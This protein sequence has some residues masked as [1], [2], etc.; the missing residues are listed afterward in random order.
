[1]ITK[2]CNS[3]QLC[4]LVLGLSLVR[5]VVLCEGVF[6]ASEVVNG[7][8]QLLQTQF[9]DVD[10]FQ[11][12]TGGG[13][14]HYERDYG[15][16][17]EI[18]YG[19]NHY[20]TVRKKDDQEWVDIYDHL[21]TCTLSR[22]FENPM[23]QMFGKTGMRNLTGVFHPCS[24]QSLNN[25]AANSMATAYI[26][27]SGG[28]PDSVEY[29]QSKLRGWSH[30]CLLY[31]RLEPPPMKKLSSPRQ[32]SGVQNKSDIIVN[33][34]IICI[35][36]SATKKGYFDS[37][38]SCRDCRSRFHAPC[39]EIA[40]EPGCDYTTVDYTCKICDLSIMSLRPTKIV[41]SK[42]EQLHHRMDLFRDL[43]RQQE[44]LSLWD[45]EGWRI[46]EPEKCDDTKYKCD[47]RGCKVINETQSSKSM[48]TCGLCLK[49]YHNI[50]IGKRRKIP[51]AWVC[52]NCQH[53]R[54]IQYYRA[55]CEGKQNDDDNEMKMQSNN[56]SNNSKN[57]DDNNHSKNSNKSTERDETS[58]N[59]TNLH[60]NSTLV[61]TVDK[62]Q[63][64]KKLC[65][66]NQN[67]NNNN[68]ETTVK[69]VR[70]KKRKKKKT[71]IKQNIES[72]DIKMD[73]KNSSTTKKKLKM[74]QK[75]I[76]F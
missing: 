41:E 70:K 7:F 12:T 73:N 13:T 38:I 3:L 30:Q 4:A 39:L 23:G 24:E 63:S 50:C 58:T 72:T 36:G 68:S 51:E 43:Q 27:A 54:W 45:N 55:F 37:I 48:G 16:C 67:K 21:L 35:C 34:E 18:L 49:N 17:V 69:I 33:I 9:G 6:V 64:D 22:E 46:D 75:I 44:W 65:K 26:L 11:E 8:L 10:G 61:D 56:N 66:D 1:M 47:A 60:L 31:H 59:Q 5:I 20:I 62:I 57:K 32:W 14:L 2:I 76:W 40:Y 25:C 52:P 29:D 53:L 15:H 42:F 28:D 19:S 74:F 71:N